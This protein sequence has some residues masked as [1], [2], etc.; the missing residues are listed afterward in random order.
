MEKAH[1]SVF[2]LMLQML[3]DGRLTDSKG[4]TVNFKNSIV[5]FT[6]NIG[7]QSILALGGDPEKD[8]E[9]R[10]KVTAAMREAFRPEFLNRIDDFISKYHHYDN[11]SCC[12]L[13]IDNN[14]MAYPSH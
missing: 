8:E 10:A 6:S 1:P 12:Y 14:V 13:S 2:N 7:S 4:N 11:Y 3:D 5:I 9:M